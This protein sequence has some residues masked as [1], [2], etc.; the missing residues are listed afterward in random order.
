[1]ES[2]VPRLQVAI[3]GFWVFGGKLLGQATIYSKGV[4]NMHD[5]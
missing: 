3:L 4:E 2:C 1:L 5:K